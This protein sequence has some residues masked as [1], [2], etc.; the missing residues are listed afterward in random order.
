MVVQGKQLQRI[1]RLYKDLDD[2]FHELAL[3][4][5]LS[6]SA[7]LIFYAIAELGDGC[8]Q[9]EIADTYYASRQTI[10]SSIKRLE[11]K[12]YL[13]LV[14]G[15][16]REMHIHLTSSGKYLMEQTIAPVIDMENRVLNAMPPEES[17]ELLRLLE[18]YV[19]LYHEK[20]K[21]LF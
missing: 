19:C 11:G 8:L 20:A 3:K 6:D 7:F 13:A 4:S 5:G 18:K 15:K 1:N 12:G 14:P 17:R 16:R 10:N 9:T 21:E 2:V